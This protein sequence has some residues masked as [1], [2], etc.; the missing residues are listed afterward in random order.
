MVGVVW[1]TR[2]LHGDL[3]FQFGC[4][5]CGNHFSLLLRF[6]RLWT[7]S[8]FARVTFL[9]PVSRCFGTCF[10]CTKKMLSCFAA[11]MESCLIGMTP[12]ATS[13]DRFPKFLDSFWKGFRFYFSFRVGCLKLVFEVSFGEGSLGWKWTQSRFC[14]QFWTRR[15]AL[16]SVLARWERRSPQAARTCLTN[17][18][19]IF[20]KGAADS[21]S[22]EAFR[23]CWR[24]FSVQ[25]QSKRLKE[26]GLRRDGESR[27][28]WTTI[29]D[30]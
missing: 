29:F 28:D 13:F 11:V 9:L 1:W 26:N 16:I 6:A 24:Q 10:W 12:N 19:S 4:W 22:V 17:L 7:K 14:A 5:I 27:V 15:L 21:F 2:Q 8:C 18:T 25:A 23:E 20:A 3:G 30:S